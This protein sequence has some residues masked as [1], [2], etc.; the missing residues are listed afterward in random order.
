MRRVFGWE[1]IKNPLIVRGFLFKKL[2]LVMLKLLQP[3][4]ATI[5]KST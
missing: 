4:Q 3:G 5:Q 1:K 2:Y